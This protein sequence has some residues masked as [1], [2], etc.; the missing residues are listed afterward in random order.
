MAIRSKTVGITGESMYKRFRGPTIPFTVPRTQTADCN[1]PCYLQH[2]I[3]S[4]ILQKT[5]RQCYTS[6]KLEQHKNAETQ[7]DYRESEAQTEPWEPPYKVIPGI[8][9]LYLVKKKLEIIVREENARKDKTRDNG[10]R[11]CRTI[12]ISL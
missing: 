11:T 8:V 1:S 10:M 9:G 2:K 6:P 5:Q 3:L 12:I 7:T 4:G